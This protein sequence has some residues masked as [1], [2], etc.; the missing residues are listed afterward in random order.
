MRWKETNFLMA[1]GSLISVLLGFVLI[2]LPYSFWVTGALLLLFGAFLLALCFIRRKK[3]RRLLLLLAGIGV[4]V[5]ET[6]MGW[7]LVCG[8]TDPAALDAQTAVVL[9]AQVN[10]SEPSSILKTRLDA[11]L[12]YMQEN[13]DAAVILSGGKGGGENLPEAQ[14]MYQ[15]LCEHGADASRLY[16]EDQ[17]STTLENLRNSAALAEREG[18]PFDE[19]CIITSE[20]HLPRADYLAGRL[21][22]DAAGYSA[23]S[24]PWFFKM[25]YCLREIPA[26]LKAWWQTR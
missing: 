10:G 1:F 17:S 23:H 15:Y 19:I 12:T 16:V 9:G 7:I 4:V 11:T 5:L 8:Q 25:N 13:P 6:L 2:V 26:F 14:A 20:F 22:I 24:R 21:G 18:I 3:V